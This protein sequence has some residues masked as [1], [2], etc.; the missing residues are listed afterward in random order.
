MT[1]DDLKAQNLILFEV[2]SG[3][4]AFGLATET[5]D[6]DIKGVFYLPKDKFYGLEYI[7]QISN[8]TNDIVYYELG[9]FVEL[10]LKSNPNILEVLASAPDCILY[11]HPIMQQLTLDLFLSQQTK[12]TFAHYAMS[13]IKKAKGL[14]KKINNPIEVKRKTVLDFCYI[15][16][17]QHAYPLT[18]WLSEKRFEQHLCGLVNIPHSRDLY[19]LFYDASGD[20]GYHGIIQNDDSTEL[21]LSSVKVGTTVNAYLSFNRDSFS[22]HCRDYKAYWQWVEKRNEQR[23]QSNIKSG[24]DFDAKNMMHTIRLLQVAHEIMTKGTITN[25][26]ANRDELLAIKNGQLSYDEIMHISETLLSKIEIASIT[27]MLPETP[28]FTKAIA[29]LVKMREL[30]YNH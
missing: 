28:N 3:S 5:S 22:S 25:K 13:Q 14:N 24:N 7:P 19:A 27:S 9:R 18:N 15:I 26:C 10:L 6:T 17:G 11:Q 4:R 30:L 20:C 16:Q 12:Q 29:Q 8:E 23:Y 2:I 1:I 21:C